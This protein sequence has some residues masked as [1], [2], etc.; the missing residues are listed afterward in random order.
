MRIREDRAELQEVGAARAALVKQ[1]EQFGIE[2]VFVDPIDAGQ[3]AEETHGRRTRS[4][5]STRGTDP[6]AAGD[7]GTT[8]R[9]AGTD[10]NGRPAT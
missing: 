5:R 10:R 4:N 8:A 6:H 1:I 3:G 7:A 9:R 2:V